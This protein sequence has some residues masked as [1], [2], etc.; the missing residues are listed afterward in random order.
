MTSPTPP[1]GDE[2][3]PSGRLSR[4]TR[5][6]GTVGTQWRRALV[7]DWVSGVPMRTNSGKVPR[8]AG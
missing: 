4:R 7:R 3:R 6:V 5:G 1:Y 8:S 2:T